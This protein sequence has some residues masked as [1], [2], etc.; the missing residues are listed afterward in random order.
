[1]DGPAPAAGDSLAPLLTLRA[2]GDRTP[3]F[4]VPPGL[5]VGW[6]YA[7]LLP[8]LH[9]DR[10]VHALQ[11]PA[12]SGAGAA[13]PTSVR[14][15]AR[16]CL[17]RVRAVQA[18]GPYLL[19][20][21]SFGGPVAHEM[22]VLLRAAGEEVALLAVVDAMP[23]PPETAR[24]PLPPDVVAAEAARILREEGAALDGIGG[25]RRAALGEAIARHV[26]LGRAWVPS[27]Y[28]GTVTLFAATRDPE[29]VPTEEKAAAWRRAAPRVDVHELACAHAEVLDAGPAA[30]IARTVEAAIETT[31]GTALPQGPR[32]TLQG[33]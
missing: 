29:A 33:E 4:C 3:L 10:P 2:A 15:V 7:S 8:H 6:A 27:R 24:T 23:K 1:V 16:D 22:A 5:G 9:P 20:G 13:P 30:R 31:F 12:L 21:R 14:D 11:T 18:H 32:T 17:D 28:D 19:L 26:E 25:P